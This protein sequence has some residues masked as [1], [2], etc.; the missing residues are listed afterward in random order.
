[1]LKNHKTFRAYD[2]TL[3]IDGFLANEE[4]KPEEALSRFNKILEWFPNSRFEP[5]AHMMRAEYEFTKDAPDYQNAYREYEEVL[6]FKDTELYDIALFKS[7]WTL[8]RLGKPAEAAR[9]FLKVFQATEDGSKQRRRGN[10][11]LQT[12]SRSTL[13]LLRRDENPS[14]GTVQVPGQAA[15]TIFAGTIVLALAEPHDLEARTAGS[16]RTSCSRR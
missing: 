5:D 16:R 14:A 13:F 4:N 10:R 11:R 2:L 7:A 9:R 3:Y 6:K 8:W 12:E 15:V 1:M